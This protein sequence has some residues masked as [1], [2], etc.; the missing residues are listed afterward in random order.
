M[1]QTYNFVSTHGIH[2]LTYLSMT[3]TPM[4][5]KLLFEFAAAPQHYKIK[6]YIN[7][8]KPRN[9]LRTK[10]KFKNLYETYFAMFKIQEIFAAIK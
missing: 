7:N 5:E 2:E 9:K 8:G 1:R 3:V 4:S 6:S 10:L